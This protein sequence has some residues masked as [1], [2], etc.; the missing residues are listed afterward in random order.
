MRNINLLSYDTSRDSFLDDGKFIKKIS[1]IQVGKVIL[2]EQTFQSLASKI[3]F[4]A[5]RKSSWTCK[6]LFDWCN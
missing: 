2:S 5:C 3:T 1:T 4:T 6:Y